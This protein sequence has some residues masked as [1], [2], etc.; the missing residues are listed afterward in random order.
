LEC[1]TTLFKIPYALD[2]LILIY[3]YYYYYFY[4]EKAAN[5]ADDD[6]PSLGIVVF[7]N[8]RFSAKT[9]ASRQYHHVTL[10]LLPLLNR[11]RALVVTLPVHHLLDGSSAGETSAHARHGRR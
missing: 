9:D 4:Q 7:P 2:G 3:Y 5:S 11:S 8:D 10:V 1:K 6:R